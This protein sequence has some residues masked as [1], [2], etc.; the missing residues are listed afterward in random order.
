MAQVKV[1]AVVERGR[2]HRLS[3]SKI[4]DEMDAL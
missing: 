4:D 3:E 1:T 2:G